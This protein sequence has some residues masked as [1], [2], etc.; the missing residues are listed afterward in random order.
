[1]TDRLPEQLAMAA[2]FVRVVDAG[3]FTAASRSLGMTK[4]AVSK[5]V[6]RLESRLGTQLL[7]RTTRSMGMTEAGQRYYEGVASALALM[8]DAEGALGDLEPGPTGLL[9]V[10]APLSFGRRCV[11]PH[12]PELLRLHPGLQ[13]QLVLLDRP[14]DLAEEGFDLAVRIGTPL[15]TGAVA[16]KLTEFRYRLCGAAQAFPP[17][18]RPREPEGL[19]EQACLRYGDGETSSVWEFSGAAGLRRVRVDGPLRVNSSE[20]L[21]AMVLAGLGV[22]LLPDFLVADDLRAGR[23]VELLPG[24][25]PRPPFGTTVH[26]LRLPSRFTPAKVRAFTDFLAGKLAAPGR[27]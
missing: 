16:R 24:W 7:R 6:A 26:L 15:P 25:T 3:G 1:M 19:A 17:R 23:L 18:R 10:T 4:S 8:R 22:A 11:E 12:L 9:R 2:V 5:Q 21:L 13:L 20:S 14:V 27:L